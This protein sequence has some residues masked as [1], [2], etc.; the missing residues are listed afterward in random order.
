MPNLMQFAMNLIQKN[1]TVAN[2]PDAQNLLNVIQSGDSAKGQQIAENLCETYG[3]SKE[4]ALA[5]AK[6]FFNIPS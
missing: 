1:P 6:K 3:V 2:N 5:Q 4:D